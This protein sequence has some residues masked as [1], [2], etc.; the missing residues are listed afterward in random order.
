MH[1]CIS[2]P[3]TPGLVKVTPEKCIAIKTIWSSLHM[4]DFTFWVSK[5][6]VKYYQEYYATMVKDV[7]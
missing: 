4:A 6:K 5:V 7:P 3:P 1:T 2:Q